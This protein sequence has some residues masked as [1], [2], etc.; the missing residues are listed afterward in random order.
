MLIF[1]SKLEP[2]SETTQ[3][4]FGLFTRLKTLVKFL[5]QLHTIIPPPAL[6]LNKP[7][8]STN[9]FT[10]FRDKD[11]HDTACISDNSDDTN[12][13]WSII[14]SATDIF[15][16]LRALDRGEACGPDGIPGKFLGECA[17]ELSH[18]L[19][20][21]F[22][23]SLQQG[24]VP[25]AWKVANV[26][27]V[28]KKGDNTCVENYRPISLLSVVSKVLERCIHKKILPFL[29]PIISDGQHG[30]C[31]IGLVLLNLLILLIILVLPMTGDVTPMLCNWTSRRHLTRSTIPSLLR[32]SG[33]QVS[34]P[35]SLPGSTI[36]WRAD[37]REWS[38][39][40]RILTC[41]QSQLA[42][43]KVLFLGPYFL[44]SLSIT[45]HPVSHPIHALLSLSTMPNYIGRFLP[46]MIKWLCRMTSV[47]LIT[48]VKLGIL[49]LM[50]KSVWCFRLKLVN[51]T[52][53]LLLFTDLVTTIY[54]LLL[55][56]MIL[57]SW[58]LMI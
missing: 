51:V 37:C 52:M 50:Q 58:S 28:F 16:V 4:G 47:L 11:S 31:Q 27:P 57:V 12:S 18:S 43:H 22:N 15:D 41:Y 25:S 24:K 10:V 21:I 20:V 44:L 1:S 30:L 36:I 8:S 45:C 3:R 54:F 26:T 32:S 46:L 5:I 53:L 56:K 23:A 49:I 6:R 55:V 35:H 9:I 2:H 42:S 48:R 7:V 38:S 33:M 29:Q 19:T 13:L 17:F 14:F 40:V 34:V 39:V